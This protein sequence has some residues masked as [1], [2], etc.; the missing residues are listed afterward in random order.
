MITLIREK[1]RFAFR[2][3]DTE[4]RDRKIQEFIAENV[5]NGVSETSIIR[6]MLFAGMQAMK[7]QE[8]KK[9]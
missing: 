5:E 8:A 7:E 6:E 1:W 3:R 4:L 9:K 2:L